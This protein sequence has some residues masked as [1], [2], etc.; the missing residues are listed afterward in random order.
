M[1]EIG[2]LSFYVWEGVMTYDMLMVPS[3]KGGE[4]EANFIS[5]AVY[6]PIEWKTEVACIVKYVHSKDPVGK[7]H[8]KQSE[9]IARIEIVDLSTRY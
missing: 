1:I 3:V 4:H 9:P 7:R 2:V 5:K 6:L 8:S